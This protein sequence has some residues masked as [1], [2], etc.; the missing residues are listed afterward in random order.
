M[1]KYNSEVEQLIEK[2]HN[3]HAWFEQVSGQEAEKILQS[4]PLH[5]YLL[6][7]GESDLHYFFSYVTENSLVFH[8]SI[9]INPEAAG[10]YANGGAG[11]DRNK[12]YQTVEPLISE[13][14]NCNQEDLL[15]LSTEL[16]QAQGY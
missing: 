13:F 3:H 15:P 14:L 8:K 4:Y 7:A 16:T 5:S 12:I 6:R 1:N 9:R 11:C 10:Y 2:M